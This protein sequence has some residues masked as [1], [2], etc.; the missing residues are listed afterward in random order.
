[1]P[2]RIRRLVGRE[3]HEAGRVAT[4]LELLYD[5]TFAVSFSQ[6]GAAF[7]HEL[8]IGTIWPAIGAYAVAGFAILWAW[9]NFSWYASAF[10]SDDIAHRLLTMVQMVGVVLLALGIPSFFASLHATHP[11]NRLM[12]AGYVVMRVAMVVQW[13]RVA[14]DSTEYRQVALWSAG[15]TALMQVAWTALLIAHTTWLQ[16]ALVAGVIALVEVGLPVIL[17]RRHRLPWHGHHMA[18]RYSLLAIITLG[19]GVIGT[20]AALSSSIEKHG[21]WSTEALA[22]VVAG[23]VLTFGLWWAYFTMD[24]G[25]ALSA[26]RRASTAF[27][28]AHFLILLGLAATGAGLHLAGYV[29]EGEAQIPGTV[30][31]AAIAVPVL[32]FFIGVYGLYTWFVPEADLRH[33]ILIALTV[34]ILAASVAMA[35]AGVGLAW[36]L[37]VLMLAPVPTVVGYEWFGHRHQDDALA[38]IEQTATPGLD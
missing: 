29:L 10:D 8:S 5:L 32:L 30:A 25:R 2:H 33:L 18:E 31:I 35:A 34:G 15:A 3:P 14:K 16:F 17:E 38:R 21:G 4:P 11:D 28:A 6:A 1:M 20:I 19:E 7:A 23:I 22:V 12:V 13:L 24:F 27:I 36:C 26:V 9:T 37:A